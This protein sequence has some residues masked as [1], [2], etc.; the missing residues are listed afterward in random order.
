MIAPK[1]TIGNFRKDEP[2]NQA[3]L[4]EQ[5]GQLMLKTAIKVY[6]G[7]KGN[8]YD[9]DPEVQLAIAQAN[10]NEDSALV[11]KQLSKIDTDRENDEAIKNSI[12]FIRTDQEKTTQ[13]FSDAK[14]FSDLEYL[15]KHGN[16]QQRK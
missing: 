8:Y 14:K 12:S 9:S 1:P 15:S 5:A 16:D 4:N 11:D 13:V 10:T 7:G 2:M 3:Q 6:G